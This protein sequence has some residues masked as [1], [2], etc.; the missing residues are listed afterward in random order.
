MTADQEHP[1]VEHRALAIG[2]DRVTSAHLGQLDL[3]VLGWQGEG[4]EV[5]GRLRHPLG[6][7]MGKMR[8]PGRRCSVRHDQQATAGGDPVRRAAED[9]LPRERDRGLQEAGVDE[10]VRRDIREA[11]EVADQE[12]DAGRAGGPS[13]PS[14]LSRPSMVGRLSRP[15]MVGRLSRPDQTRSLLA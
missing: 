14:R 1:V 12:P 10:M 9:Q 8:R 2:A 13:R 6:M 4:R 7:V 5:V 15:S 3:P 11:L